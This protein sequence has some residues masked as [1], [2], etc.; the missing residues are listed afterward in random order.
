[1]PGGS[2]GRGGT[3]QAIRGCLSAGGGEGHGSKS[4]GGS[5]G[6]VQQCGDG[7]RVW[8]LK[9]MKERATAQPLCG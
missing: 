6:T 4:Q 8:I 2:A 9:I 5:P 1:M 3:L 7:E